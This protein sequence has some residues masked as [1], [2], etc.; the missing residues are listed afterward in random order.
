VSVTLC[1]A[2]SELSTSEPV[3]LQRDCAMEDGQKS[4]LSHAQSFLIDAESGEASIWGV[5]QDL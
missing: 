2:P 5:A 3:G 4:T 1:V